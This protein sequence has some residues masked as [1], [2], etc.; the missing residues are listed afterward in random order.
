MLLSPRLIAP[1]KGNS[2]ILLNFIDIWS[3]VSI[4]KRTC[5]V[6]EIVCRSLNISCKWRVPIVLRNVVWASRRVEWCAFSTFASEELKKKQNETNSWKILC[7]ILF[8][9][10]I[11]LHWIH[12]NKRL[13]L[14]IPSHYPSLAPINNLNASFSL[15]LYKNVDVSSSL[16]PFIFIINFLNENYENEMNAQLISNDFFISLP[17]VVE[18]HMF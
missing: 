17:L 14:L 5:I 15:Y 12:D 18:H 3:I 8:Y 4:S 11:R 7:F 6:P 9:L 1:E 13:H 2:Y 16:K 10:L